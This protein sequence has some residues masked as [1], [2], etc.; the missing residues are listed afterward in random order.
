MAGSTLVLAPGLVRAPHEENRALSISRALSIR[1]SEDEIQILLATPSLDRPYVPLRVFT[2]DSIQS[3]KMQIARS[4]GFTLSSQVSGIRLVS[5][6]RELSREDADLS[7]YGINRSGEV[8]HLALR[9]AD[10]VDVKVR[11]K[12]GAEKTFTLEKGSR[13]GDLKQKIAKN[14]EV[15]DVED[16]QLVLRG[17]PLQEGVLVEDLA[18]DINTVVHLLIPGKTSKVRVKQGKGK[19]VELSVESASAKSLRRELSLAV[20]D[21]SESVKEK[22][23]PSAHDQLSLLINPLGALSSSRCRSSIQVLVADAAA[24]L[25]LHSPVLSLGGMGAAYFLANRSGETVAVF[26]PLDEEPLA[27]NN[28]R[29]LPPSKN[30]EGLKRG[31]RVGEGAA[32]EVH[33][34]VFKV[35]LLLLSFWHFTFALDVITRRD[36]AFAFSHQFISHYCRQV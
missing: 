12:A 36:R 29:G 31:T 21:F 14:G 18:L 28:P 35:S 34:F 10:L 3:V 24:G 20:K 23:L 25:L 6:G 9:L 5:G 2:T 33:F 32:R 8:L 7:S 17:R 19:H 11:T 30:G 22:S 26:K 1:P 16:A 15:P 4:H 13:V 27:V